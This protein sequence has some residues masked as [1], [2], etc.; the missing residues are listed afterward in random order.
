MVISFTGAQ[1]TGKSTLLNRCKE[2]FGDKFSYVEE[3]TRLVKRQYNVPIN[4]GGTDITQCL[5]M[6]QHIINSIQYP[7]DVIMDRCVVDGTVYTTYLA[8]K[9]KVSHWVAEYAS[10]VAN[11]LISKIDIIFLCTAEFDVVDDGVRSIDTAF[12]NEIA[13]LMDS[14]ISMCVPTYKVVRLTGSVEDRMNTIKTT[15]SKYEEN[16]RA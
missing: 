10:K 1:S 4:E 2:E 12:R 6:N 14:C 15:I 13:A 5:I 8:L 9:G 11:E 7:K 3:V 16:E